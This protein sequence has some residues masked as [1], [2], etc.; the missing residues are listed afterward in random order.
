MGGGR[1]EENIDTDRTCGPS[2]NP[3]PMQPTPSFSSLPQLVTAQP[4]SIFHQNTD[5]TAAE[6]E[7]K[8]GE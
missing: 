8:V 2:K 7:G 6:M 4:L 3:L 1:G 5:L